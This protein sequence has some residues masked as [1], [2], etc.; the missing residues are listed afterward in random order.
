MT[1]RLLATVLTVAALLTAAGCSDKEPTGRE[2]VPTA[3]DLYDK[4]TELREAKRTA[5][6]NSLT[7]FSWDGVFCYYEGAPTDDINSAV[8]GEVEEPG[9]RLAVSGALA[10]FVED[11]KPVRKARIPEIN[12]KIQRYSAE[13]LV[14]DGF[15]LAEPS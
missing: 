11:G 7:D 8:G 9:R 5:P 15:E 13:V 2:T 1:R 14:K 12:F 6:L 4:L 10:V 3:S